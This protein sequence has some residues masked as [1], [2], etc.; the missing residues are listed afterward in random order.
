MSCRA[1][2]LSPEVTQGRE[3]RLVPVRQRRHSVQRAR[4]AASKL[5]LGTPEGSLHW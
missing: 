3:V 5:Q 1:V 4:T 2:G